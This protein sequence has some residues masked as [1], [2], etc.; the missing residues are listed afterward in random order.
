MLKISKS[1]IKETYFYLISHNSS[2]AK[3]CC[4]IL[5]SRLK[6]LKNKL[7]ANNTIEKKATTAQI[8]SFVIIVSRNLSVEKEDNTIRLYFIIFKF[9]LRDSLSLNGWYRYKQLYQKYY[10]V[11]LINIVYIGNFVP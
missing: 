1:V 9:F 3:K 6:F 5:F 8:F 2:V 10:L 4:F 7:K 11:V